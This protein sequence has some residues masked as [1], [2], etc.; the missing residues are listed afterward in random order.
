MDVTVK[1]TLIFLRKVIS[2]VH[3]LLMLNQ[4]FLVLTVLKNVK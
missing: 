2:L 4:C 3:L 1:T